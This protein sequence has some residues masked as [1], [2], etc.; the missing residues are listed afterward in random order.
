M[1][2]VESQGAAL[3]VLAEQAVKRAAVIENRQIVITV[4]QDGRVAELRKSLA[5][6]RANPI[7][8]TVGGQRIEV[9]A[10]LAPPRVHSGSMAGI[11]PVQAAGARPAR[12]D[13]TLIQAKAAGK[14]LRVSKGRLG[15]FELGG[16]CRRRQQ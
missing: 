8:N 1:F 4:L 7:G 2:L 15:K 13:L 9:V 3:P 5:G 12:R 16:K 14:S 11:V 6:C 10:G